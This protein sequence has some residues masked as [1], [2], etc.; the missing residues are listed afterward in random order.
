MTWRQPYSRKAEGSAVGWQRVE[1]SHGLAST[2]VRSTSR[3]GMS[4]SNVASCPGCRRES[5]AQWEGGICT[6]ANGR[7]EWK[8][9]TTARFVGVPGM[10]AVCRHLAA[11]LNVRFRTPVRPPV[12]DRG[13]WRLED[14]HE[15][16]LGEFDY[17]VTSAPAPQSAALLASARELQQQAESVEM[18][19]C[20]A[21]MLAFDHPLDLP[22]DGAFVQDSPLSWIARNDS[23]PERGADQSPGFYTRH[24]SGPMCIWEMSRT[25]CS[26]CCLTPSGERRVPNPGQANHA[27]S[28]RWRYAIPLKPLDS[29]CLFDSELRVGACGDW[30]A[31]PRVEGAFLSGMAIAHRVLAGI[32]TN[33]VTR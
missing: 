20:W 23:K 28:H 33:A 24:R 19:G 11:D 32:E 26:R 10:N 31:G 30:C 16:P 5:C 29:R 18:H 15:R 12:F 8:Q 14:E 13:I 7:I 9:K 4:G 2:T 22:F 6:L 1:R 25:M 21:A 27:A 3:S 17:F